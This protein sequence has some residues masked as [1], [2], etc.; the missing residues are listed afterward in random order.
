VKGL[1]NQMGQ[2][3]FIMWQSLSLA[4]I[5]LNQISGTTQNK[6]GTASI[7]N[8]ASNMMMQHIPLRTKK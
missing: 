1:S 3:G 4:V 7:S 8:I 2:N 6:K 5:T